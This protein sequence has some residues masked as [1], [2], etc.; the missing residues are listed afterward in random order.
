MQIAVELECNA[1]LF[2]LNTSRRRVPLWGSG[3]MMCEVRER[4][5]DALRARRN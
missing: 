5:L 2:D 4:H 3:A 1:I